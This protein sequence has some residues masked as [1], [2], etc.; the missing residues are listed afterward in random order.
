MLSREG[1]KYRNLVVVSLNLCTAI[2]MKIKGSLARVPCH[3]LE[4]K[5]TS[6]LCMVKPWDVLEHEK[7]A[8]CSPSTVS[9]YKRR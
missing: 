9:G 1:V 2:C 5:I 8:C 6:I 4:N 7:S 3:E